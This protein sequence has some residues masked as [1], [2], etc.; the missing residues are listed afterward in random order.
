MTQWLQHPLILKGRLVELRPVEEETLDELFNVS[1][2]PNIWRLTSVAYSDP[3]IFYPNFKAAL[4]DREHGK[5]YPLLMCLAGSGQ[6]IGTTR[7]L[8][9]HPH[10]K[11]IE[12]GVTW[13]ACEF[14]GT[15]INT[16]CKLLL[17]EHCFETLGANRVQF[18]AKADNARSRRALE[19]I[20]ATFEGVMRKD[21]IEPNGNARDTALY[22]IVREEWPSVK[23]QLVARLASR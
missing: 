21:K 8:D 23:A 9:I 17:L 15:G 12:I 22:S 11:K 5:V 4:R 13:M 18:R 10:D 6:I 7:L 1:R 2:D 14:W 19:K 16:E 20:G 3:A